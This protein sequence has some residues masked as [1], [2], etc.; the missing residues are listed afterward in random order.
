MNSPLKRKH[1][2]SMA[3]EQG[4]KNPETAAP[5]G[6]AV[7]AHSYSS[8]QSS[9]FSFSEKLAS[10]SSLKWLIIV[11]LPVLILL[12]YPVDRTDSDLWWQM[13]NGRYFIEHHTLRID[14]SIFS[15][16][17]ADGAWIYNTC[18]GSIA[19][20][21]FYHFMGGFGLWLMQWMI[22]GGIFLS[23]YLF[24]R[25]LNRRLDINK[26]TLIGA[27]GIAC[28]ISCSFY[29]PELFSALLFAWTVFIFFYIRIKRT[30][31]LFYLYPLLF[32]LWVNLHGAFLVG[33]VFLA[34]AFA[35]EFLN[36]I[37][38]ARESLTTSELVHF[39]AAGLLS[40]ASTLLNPYGAD[41]LLGLLP[42]IK[43]AIVKSH[44]ENLILAHSSLWPY[45]KNISMSFFYINVTVWLMAF[46]IFSV[47]I[48]SVYEF[49][50]KKSFDF[51]LLIVSLVL[52]W[53]GMQTGRASYFFLIAFFFISFYLL[54]HRLILAIPKGRATVISLPVLV[55]LF[56]SIAYINIRCQPDN[57]WFGK[58]LESFVPARE[59]AFL[60]IHKL[61]GPV[62]NDY[63]TGGYLLWALYPDYKVFIDPRHVPY[64]NE[65]SP[66]YWEFTSRPATAEDINRFTA[67][68]P[69]KTAI[70]SYSE[71]P[72]IF[73]FLDADDQWRLLYFEKN[74]AILIHKSLLPAAQA[75]ADI[76]D[77]GPQRFCDVK[78]PAILY[79]IFK[80]YVRLNP[81]EARH[82]YNIAKTNI[83]DYYRKKTELLDAMDAQILLRENELQDQSTPLR[84]DILQEQKVI[85][86]R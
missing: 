63:V 14:P 73:S 6:P 60:K 85:K 65:V 46:M 86:I 64:F 82:I 16:T 53:K 21:L 18:L 40:G 76:V 32:A 8:G 29:K 52:Y 43:I 11:L 47:L 78:D 13:A 3:D 68:Y 25:L 34:L 45:L 44:T 36:R 59:V 4:K 15:W 28:S 2:K 54:F 10:S 37:F 74:A 48:F 55:F 56:I 57:N 72:L 24:L 1:N 17:P 49:I 22:F 69:F 84:S 33:L 51:T 61:E 30:K 67:K 39:A 79:N 41:Y 20:Y 19:V 5:G 71:M 66:D 38:F 81:K 7:N 27:I 70:I 75:G 77:L 62:F 80:L 35:G 83:S 9:F 31:Y 26:L 50:K 58:G 42:T 23:F 12:S